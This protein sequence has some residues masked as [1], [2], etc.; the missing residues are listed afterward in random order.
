MPLPPVIF[1]ALRRLVG[2][3]AAERLAVSGQLLSPRD[4]ALEGMVD[5]VVPPDQVV[6]RAIE[7]CQDLLALSQTAVNLTRRQARA[8][9]VMEFAR[10]MDHE[11]A[12]VGSWWWN[13]ETQTAL[14]RL[15][16][17]LVIKKKS[18]AL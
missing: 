3:R 14:H 12:Q 18:G 13:Q 1:S 2:A 8:D 10:D 9:L 16:E 17:Q 5:E 15:V 11:L 4:A 6:V 7:W